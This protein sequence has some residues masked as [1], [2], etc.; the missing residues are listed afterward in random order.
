[1]KVL[2]EG[3]LAEDDIYQGE[4]FHCGAVVEFQR[5]EARYVSDQRD[6]DALVV[7]CPTCS[8]EIW[9]AVRGM[10]R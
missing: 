6:G 2:R 3:R 9:T 8:N 1:M 5:K 4:C 7:V 10:S